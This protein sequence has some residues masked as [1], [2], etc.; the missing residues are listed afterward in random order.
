MTLD[1]FAKFRENLERFPDQPALEVLSDDGRETFTYRRIDDEIRKV[2]LYFQR[3]GIRPGDRVGILIENHP[4]WGIA[5]LAAQ[6][7]G[8]VVVPLD[9]LHNA[10]TL[11][12]LIRH[13]GC[14]HL[15][16]A[17]KQV[18]AL[19]QI[20]ERLSEPLPV[21]VTG[22][23]VGGCADWEAVLAEPCG[24]VPLPL[25]ERTLDDELVIIYTSGT[26]GNQ[27][28]VVLTQRNIYR[29]TVEILQL[30]H[31]TAEDRFL[32]VLPL[33]HVFA[34]MTNF[35]IPL[36]L[37]A[38]VA[39]LQSLEAQRVLRTFRE[40]NITVFVCVPQFYN[41]VHRR[42]FQE[43]QRQGF[44]KRFLFRRL[45]ALS[46]LCNVRLGFNPGRAFFGAIHEKFGRQ[47]K[48][49]G[50]GGARFD[51]Q[52]V[53]DFRDLGFPVVQAFG[54]TE[55]AALVTVAPAGGHFTGTVGRS[56]PHTR[57]RIEQPDESGVGE[58]LV[59]GENVMKG[60]WKNPEA[61]AEALQD[62][63]LRTG[64]LGYIDRHGCL[65]ITGRMKDVIVLSSGKN[66]YPE[67]VEHFYLSS[68]PLIKEMC[69]LGM[70][71]TASGDQEERLH[72]VIVPDVDYLNAQQIANAYDAIRW[73]L[74]TLSQK[75]P[76]YKRV[77]SF[78]VRMEP[79]PVTTT[80]KLKRFEIQKLVMEKKSEPA[81]A[82]PLP[83]TKPE[84]PAEEKIFELIRRLKEGAAIR[85]EMSLELDLGFTSLE[86][87]ELLA[88]VQESFGIRVPDEEAARILTVQEL[89]AAVESRLA[90]EAAGEGGRL[91]WREL[92]VAPLQPEDEGRLNNV[93][94]RRRW[95]E[96]LYWL[97]GRTV[98]LAALI[99][100]RARY[101]GLENLPRRYPYLICPNHVSFLDA[102][103]VACALPYPV[104]RRMFIL[105]GVEFFSG[106][107][108]S[109]LGKLAKVVTVSPDRGLR[110]SL[111]FSA[112]GL[113][114]GL[115]LLVFPEGERSIDG[116]LTVFR[117]GPAILALELNAPVVPVGIVGA[118][119]IWP[120]GSDR[121][122]LHPVTVAYCKPL[123]PNKD[124]ES[125]E[126]FTARLRDA[127]GELLRRQ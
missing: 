66:I 110:D 9:V 13:A 29:N 124:A 44:L 121:F 84:T 116:A 75:I 68:C 8:A 125:Y 108:T 96:P 26:T 111:R 73:H 107:V 34:L 17:A 51:S 25:V 41:L 2:S 10:E 77:R 79:L 105:G 82:A 36:Y 71:G 23:S 92:L 22:A 74:E 60:Y 3:A 122:R 87:V 97:I 85:R 1:F 48:V 69:V 95:F 15:V 59:R 37:G 72:A 20:Q 64:D 55:T 119:E 7:A 109:F 98:R 39:Y 40:E 76:A 99:L 45:L 5:F 83:E 47:L 70:P 54:M 28:G 58:V 115:V 89:T 42:I 94:A 56:L 104:L 62:G 126:E 35:I 12:G 113:R 127:V 53:A 24:A 63:W 19:R 43:V 33:Y 88:S 102:F 117:K 80:R 49:L 31:V 50:V 91:S 30:I 67:E 78:E 11:A 65:R 100:F 46:S 6:S 16:V 101:R 112:E 81:P 93:L 120:R 14:S 4:R 38:R 123:Q 27:K 52:V 21:L 118:Y 57:I 32:S 103:L 86:R 106:A 18:P 61:T 114:R 90:G